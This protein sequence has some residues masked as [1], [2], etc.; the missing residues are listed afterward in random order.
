MVDEERQ[1]EAAPEAP[2]PENAAAGFDVD[3]LLAAGATQVA[4]IGLPHVEEPEAGDQPVEGEPTNGE[5]DDDDGDGETGDIPD[6][7]QPTGTPPEAVSTEGQ[8]FEFTKM[9]LGAPQRINEV[10][11]RLRA[12]V[13]REATAAAYERGRV[14]E[15]QRIAGGLSAEETLRSFVQEHDDQHRTDPDGFNQWQSANPREAARFWDGKNRFAD[16]AAAAVPPAPSS[17]N[18]IQRRAEARLPRLARLPA[19]TQ[20]VI[21]GRVDAGEFPLTEAGLEALDQAILDAATAAPVTAQPAAP[22]PTPREEAA[23]RR[24]AAPRAVGVASGGSAPSKELGWDVD[25]LLN[26]AALANARH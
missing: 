14:D 19:A 15:S 10:P 1:P 24:A 6:G 20:G 5:P 4:T 26:E 9:V 23:A 25:E 22:T 11:G 16:R 2:P 13:I 7:D 12:D 17:P 18:D 8:L 3:D 21:R